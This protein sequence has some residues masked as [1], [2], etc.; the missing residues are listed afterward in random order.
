MNRSNRRVFLFTA[1]AASLP[2]AAGCDS[3]KV[4][5]AVSNTVADAVAD[6]DSETLAEGMVALRG[7]EIVAWELG[8]RVVWLPVP[9][10]RIIGVSLI[11]SAGVTKLVIRYLDVELKRRHT[12]EILTVDE[13]VQLESTQEVTFRLDNGYT[14]DVPLGPN[15][16]E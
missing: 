5:R 4:D 12:E 8:K 13:A 15:Q 16:Y 3:G 7:F 11:I 2:V 6:V 1:A 10:I 9:A 14:E